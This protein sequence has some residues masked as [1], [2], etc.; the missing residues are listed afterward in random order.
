M[1]YLYQKKSYKKIILNTNDAV[2]SVGKA[3]S[4]TG[5]SEFVFYNFNT[6]TIKEP[7]Y[8]KVI[9]ASADISTNAVWN[10][11]LDNV[12]YNET[13]YYNSDADGSPT[14]LTRCFNGKS[15]LMLDNVALELPPQDMSDI[16]L[17]ILDEAGNGIGSAKMTIELCIEDITEDKM[18]T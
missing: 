14:I 16:K 17:I 1:S 2:A 4:G 10:I 18:S 9:G 5:N 13:C 12:S 6:I 3:Y 11:K 15:S 8:L 7:S